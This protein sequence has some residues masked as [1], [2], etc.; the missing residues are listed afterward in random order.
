MK[1][2]FSN[3]CFPNSDEGENHLVLSCESRV[4][5]LAFLADGVID[6]NTL[7]LSRPRRFL[8]QLRHEYVELSVSIEI[9]KSTCL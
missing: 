8:V 5:N 3:P 4:I 6:Q 1:L 2:I 9:H 7:S